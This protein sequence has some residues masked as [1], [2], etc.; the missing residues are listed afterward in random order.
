MSND[1]GGIAST[2][3]VILDFTIGSSTSTYTTQVPPIARGS[4]VRFELFVPATSTGF[5]NLYI[6]GDTTATNYFTQ[7]VQYLSSSSSAARV[8]ESRLSIADTSSSYSSGQIYISPDGK[9]FFYANTNANS[10]SGV[11]AYETWGISVNTFPSISTITLGT[12][13]ANLLATGT[14]FKIVAV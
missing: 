9:V 13:V 6:N 1:M 10:G 14:R 2:P 11:Y 12:S 4:S 3:R 7:A 5:T 8:N